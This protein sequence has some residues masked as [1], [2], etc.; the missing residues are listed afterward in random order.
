ME[1]CNAELEATRQQLRDFKSQLESREADSALS[2]SFRNLGRSQ[3]SPS[4]VT[5]R[6]PRNPSPLERVT[7]AHD[8]AIHVSN[9]WAASSGVKLQSTEKHSSGLSANTATANGY[10][11]QVYSYWHHQS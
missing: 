3:R 2:E 8:T 7:R 10:L 11:F 6:V 1:R 9:T 5:R 4:V